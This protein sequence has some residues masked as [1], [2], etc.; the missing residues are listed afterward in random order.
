MGQINCVDL[1]VNGGS[2]EAVLLLSGGSYIN[3]PTGYFKN[4]DIKVNASSSNS[5]YPLSYPKVNIENCHIYSEGLGTKHI[6][7]LPYKIYN[8]TIDTPNGTFHNAIIADAENIVT[9]EI[10]MNNCIVNSKSYT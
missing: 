2:V 4:V 7:N 10:I 9:D 8:S 1:Y 6:S 3:K 5:D